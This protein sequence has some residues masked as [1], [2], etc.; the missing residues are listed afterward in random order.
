MAFFTEKEH[1][2]GLT[3]LFTRENSKIMKSRDKDVTNGLTSHGMK[4]LLKTD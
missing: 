4:A 1:S 2:N 3:E